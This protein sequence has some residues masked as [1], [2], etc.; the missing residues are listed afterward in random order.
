MHQ[1]IGVISLRMTADHFPVLKES[2][3]LIVRVA[4]VF[5]AIGLAS[6]TVA[7]VLSFLG[8][9]T[10]PP[11]WFIPVMLGFFPLGAVAILRVLLDWRRARH[12]GQP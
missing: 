4:L 5:S 6:S 12:L 7:H 10:D 11:G 2:A 1:S 8:S 3:R 9:Y